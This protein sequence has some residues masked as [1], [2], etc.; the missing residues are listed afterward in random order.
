VTESTIKVSTK[1]AKRTVDPRTIQRRAKR[2]LVVL[3]RKNSELSVLLCDDAFI[4]QLNH[5]Y[6][7]IDKPT[8]VL[9]FS[10]NEGEE[11]PPIECDVLG[12]IVISVETASRR[13]QRNKVKLL[14]EVTGLLIHGL[15]HLLGYD[16][17]TEA[18]RKKM[19]AKASQLENIVTIAKKNSAISTINY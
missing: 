4:Q 11:M 5:Q 8:D 15:L 7:S 10:M 3:G 17:L 2:L 13:S 9:S 16:H 14:Q 18:A 12:D 1:N 19:F 6:R